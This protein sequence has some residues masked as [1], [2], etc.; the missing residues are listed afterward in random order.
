MARHFPICKLQPL[1]SFPSS[2]LSLLLQVVCCNRNKYNHCY[3]RKQTLPS[4]P[5]IQD[6]FIP[7][8]FSHLTTRQ[9][10]Q[11]SHLCSLFHEWSKWSKVGI[12]KQQPSCLWTNQSSSLH[13][14]LWGDTWFFGQITVGVTNLT[15]RAKLHLLITLFQYNI[16][17]VLQWNLNRSICTGHTKKKKKVRQILPN[18]ERSLH[19]RFQYFPWRL[20]HDPLGNLCYIHK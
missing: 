17:S 5:H 9:L 7:L 13:D 2:L 4:W 11:V 16:I 20:H 14:C 10:T 3:K 12:S 18:K 8:T 19:G 15:T 6:G 1:P